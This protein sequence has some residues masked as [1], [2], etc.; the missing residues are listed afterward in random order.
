MF[1][2]NHELRTPNSKLHGHTNSSVFI[3]Y[4]WSQS[5]NYDKKRILVFNIDSFRNGRLL[6]IDQN[7][8]IFKIF[9]FFLYFIKFEPLNIFGYFF[10]CFFRV[11]RIILG[12]KTLFCKKKLI[13]LV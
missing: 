7:Y 9:V 4:L 12:Y 8:M 13:F 5:S 3:F 11:P 6:K 10:L 2:N 1:L